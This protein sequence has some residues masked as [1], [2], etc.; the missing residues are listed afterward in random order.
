MM[1]SGT[2]RAEG[3]GDTV[4]D[5]DDKTP[6]RPKD[7]AVAVALGYEPGTE[8]APRV[9]A[10][11]RGAIAEQILQIAYAHD[12]KVREDTDL[13]QLLSTIDIDS[14]IPVEAFAAVAEI[15]IYVY[16]ANGALPDFLGGGAGGAGP[17]TED[18]HP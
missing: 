13:A 9:V 17:T 3:G 5:R 14:E 12:I 15:L 4:A 8:F 10:G 18:P 16:R 6:N 11:G 2:T 7:E 1:A